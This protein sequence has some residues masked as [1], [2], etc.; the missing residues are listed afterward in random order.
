MPRYSVRL[1]FDHIVNGNYVKRKI[2][3]G[4]LKIRKLFSIPITDVRSIQTT[5]EIV[6][7]RIIL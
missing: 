6:L 5:K 2:T 7:R 3:Y 1:R 4:V